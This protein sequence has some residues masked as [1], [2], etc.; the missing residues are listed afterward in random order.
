MKIRFCLS[1]CAHRVVEGQPAWLKDRAMPCATT[2]GIAVKLMS[3][4]GLLML[5]LSNIHCTVLTFE[6][7]VWLSLIFLCFDCLLYLVNSFQGIVWNTEI[8]GDTVMSGCTELSCSLIW[9]QLPVLLIEGKWQV[10]PC[11]PV[12]TNSLYTPDTHIHT[13]M[14]VLHWPPNWVIIIY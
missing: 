14:C 4:R 6:E 8:W 12:P 11:T 10:C 9:V 13:H 5:Y 2:F 1:N 3:H 7:C